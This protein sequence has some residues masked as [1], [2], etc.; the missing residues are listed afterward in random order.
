MLYAGYY[1]L[2]E[3]YPGSDTF[4]FFHASLAETDVLLKN[5]VLFF[6]ELFTHQYTNSGNIFIANQSYWNDL[7]SNIIIKLLAIINVFTFKN[8]NAAIVFFNFLFF[9]GLVG[10][11]K[12]IQNI[13]PTNK[14][15]LVI[16]I[17]LIPSFI[18]KSKYDCLEHIG[19]S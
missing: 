12:L 19:G 7:K 9:F 17:F 6:K 18:E 2:P 5:P 3:N 4:R 14:W 10:F 1:L 13:V 16:G 8:Y 15:L 11:Y